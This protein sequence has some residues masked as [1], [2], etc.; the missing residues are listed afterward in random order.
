MVNLDHEL[1]FSDFCLLFAGIFYY[2]VQLHQKQAICLKNIFTS[3]KSLYTTYLVK[4]GFLGR[5]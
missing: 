2:A 1:V 5:C 4:S 3:F